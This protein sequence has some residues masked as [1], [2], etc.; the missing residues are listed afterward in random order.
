MFT[1]RTTASAA[2]AA[3]DVESV[4]V[5]SAGAV[6]ETVFPAPPQ[7]ASETASVSETSVWKTVLLVNFLSVFSPYF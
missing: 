6:L 2:G 5:L 1:R 7:A 3:A 4:E